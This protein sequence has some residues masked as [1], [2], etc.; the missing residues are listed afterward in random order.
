MM[1]SIHLPVES[2]LPFPPPQTPE[3]GATIPEAAGGHEQNGGHSPDSPVEDDAS[4]TEKP[5]KRQ[6]RSRACIACRN[7]KIRCLPVQGQEAC[8]SCAK[9]NRQCVMPGPARKRQKTVHKVAELEKKIDA[10]TDALLAK[11][12]QQDETTSQPRDQPPHSDGPMTS[13][14]SD[15]LRTEETPSSI[16]SL[17][18]YDHVLLDKTFPLDKADLSVECRFLHSR[19]T[20]QEKYVDVVERGQLSEEA[21]WASFDYFL[22]NICPTAPMIAFPCG[23]KAQDVRTSKPMLFLAILTIASP[24]VAPLAQPNL[25]IELNRQLSERVLFHGERSLD[26]V[27]AILLYVEFYSRPWHGKDLAFNQY[28]HAALVMCLDLGISRR[29]RMNHSRDGVDVTEVPRTWLACYHAASRYAWNSIYSMVL[30]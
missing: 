17:P 19:A 21:A 27:Q 8:S 1:T 23:T 18:Q 5:A 30:G 3:T 14:T 12:Q 26:L 9:V 25:V 6:K 4:G 16:P 13:S 11:N 2:P 24:A 10:L 29:A 7:M 28:I 20:N 22:R 15:A